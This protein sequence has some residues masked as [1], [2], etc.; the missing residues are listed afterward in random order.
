MN[1]PHAGRLLAQAPEEADAPDEERPRR[2]PRPEPPA[3]GPQGAPPPQAPKPPP[4]PAGG[5]A[6]PVPPPPPAG[7]PPP[8][9]LPNDIVLGRAANEEELSREPCTLSSI[10]G[11]VCQKAH[12]N[13]TIRIHWNPYK[14]GGA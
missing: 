5:G 11:Y 9:P 4:D 3:E 10:E 13:G 6:T 8:S 14:Q 7:A 1:C 2:E 12:V